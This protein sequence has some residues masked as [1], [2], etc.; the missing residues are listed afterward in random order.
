SSIPPDQLQITKTNQ[1]NM[2]LLLGPS[3]RFG[4]VVELYAH[5]KGGL[6]INNSGLVSIQQRGALK[7]AYRNESTDKNIYPGFLTG[8]NVQYNT[9]SDMWSF[10]IGLDYMNTKSEVNNY[11]GRRGG[12]IEA[13]KLSRNISDIVAGFTIRYNILSPRDAASGQ[14]TGR[15]VLPTVNKRE[16]A[17][18]EPGVQI[19]IQRD[20]ATGVASGKRL[21][22]TVNK[23]EIA[24][25]EP[26]VQITVQRDQA[27]GVASGK[28]VLPTVNKKEIAIDESGVHRSLNEN[29]GPVTTKITKPDGSTEEM[30]FACTD[31]AAAYAEKINPG[32]QKN[33]LPS[34]FRTASNEGN[35]R[36]IISGRLTWP[37]SITGT[38]VITNKT[39]RGGSTTM[40]SQTS[41][42]RTTPGTSFGTMVRLAAREASSG[43]ATGKRSRE[44]GSGLATGKRQY[45]PVFAEGEDEVCNPCI[46]TAKSNPLCKGNMGGAQSNP[47]YQ[48]KERTIGDGDCNDGIAGIDVSLIDLRNDAVVAKTKTESCGDFFF[49]NV[50][51]GDYI[52]KVNG[53]FLSKKGYDIYIKSKTDLAGS[54]EQNMEPVQLMINSSET[55]DDM[56]QK[57]GISTSGSNIRTKSISIIEVDLDGDGEFESLRVN[58]SFNDG[59]SQD[60]TPQAIVNTSRSNIKQITIPLGNSSAN[61]NQKASINTTRSNIKHIAISVGDLNSDGISKII[62]TGVFTDGSNKDVTNDLQINTSHSNIRQ[63]TISLADLDGDGAADAIIKTKT[64]SNQSNDR[65]ATGDV[66]GDGVDFAINN[67][68]SNIKNLRV[69]SGDVDGDGKAELLV[70]G[71]IPG[72]SVISAK[73]P[74]DPIPGLDVKLGKN[75]GG[76]MVSTTTTNNYGEFEF[77]NLETGDYFITMEQEVI[78]DDETIVTV[79]DDY[80]TKNIN[81]SEDNPGERKVVVKGWNPTT[82]EYTKNINT[83]EDNLKDVASKSKDVKVSASQNSQTLRS[84]LIEADLDGDGEYETDVTNRLNDEITIDK[85]GQITA[86][87]MKAGV[88]TSGSNIRTRSSL[89]AMGEGLY[90]S[91]GKAVINNKEVEVRSVLKT[92]HDTVKNSINNVR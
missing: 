64:K 68:H 44:A 36:G 88:S 17:I 12:G 70:G 59:S 67:S 32:K 18:D 62:A 1:Q 85:S 41:S 40:N 37:S 2:Y 3:V 58:A 55:N 9:K 53:V 80:A 43:M 46:V 28:R 7:A 52:V 75:P 22:P 5:A 91:L 6:F 24:I 92:K 72:G 66:N 49:A 89:Q 83:S 50:P 65:V 61:S 42:T 39:I 48:G 13:L 34:N 11:D 33:W 47:L 27:T 8:L 76:H 16:I 20:Q 63:Y 45:E 79:G 15:R 73:M 21:L 51:Q 86:P 87:Q 10:G 25:D 56:M 57:A 29:C 90:V 30:T 82:K 77:T 60:V 54:I 69:A 71:F 35:D 74:G 23:R 14:S 31:D 19:T 26:G 38:G 84:I 81:T 4:K 78:I